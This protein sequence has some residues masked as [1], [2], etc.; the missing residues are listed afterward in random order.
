MQRSKWSAALTFVTIP[1]DSL[2]NAAQHLMMWIWKDNYS[3]RSSICPFREKGEGNEDWWGGRVGRRPPMGQV[4]ANSE[5]SSL[6]QVST[7]LICAKFTSA[8]FALTRIMICRTLV[9]NRG[10]EMIWFKPFEW[11]RLPHDHTL[12][13]YELIAHCEIASASTGLHA[14]KHIQIRRCHRCF[15]VDI[16]SYEYVL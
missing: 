13:E 7:E 8:G 6:S 9:K 10:Q 14:M 12:N 3:S 11:T 15:Y 1:A 2:H 16:L 5:N 4:W